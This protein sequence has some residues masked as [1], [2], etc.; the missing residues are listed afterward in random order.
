MSIGSGH[1]LS[2]FLST[3]REKGYTSFLP[4][5]MDV[6]LPH[7]PSLGSSTELERGPSPC[8]C[9]FSTDYCESIKGEINFMEDITKHGGYRILPPSGMSSKTIIAA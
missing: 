1:L 4:G 2:Q 9:L 7:L 3:L 8:S 5:P 6:L